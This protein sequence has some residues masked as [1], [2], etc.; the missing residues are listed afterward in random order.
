[1]S[2]EPSNPSEYDPS[3]SEPAEEV[4]DR[5]EVTPDGDESVLSSSEAAP[6]SQ[7]TQ[8]VIQNLWNQVQP[9]LRSTLIAALG[10][11]LSGI[12]WAIRRLEPSDSA[13]PGGQ[14]QQ[15][16]D[17]AMPDV[18]QGTEAPSAAAPPAPSPEPQGIWEQVRPRLISGSLLTLIAA[19]QG[20]GGLLKQLDAN[21]TVPPTI[22][23]A[24]AASPA[25]NRISPVFQQ[26]WQRWT[27]VLAF[28]RD[29]VPAMRQL[30]NTALTTIT[31]GVLAL[32]FWITSSLGSAPAAE[33]T[34][35]RSPELDKGEVPA[36][37]VSSKD[38]DTTEPAE[39]TPEQTLIA[40]LQ[41]Q[42][43]ELS[44][45]YADGLIQ[46][47]EANFL[48][49]RLTINVEPAWYDLAPQRQHQLA[50][51]MLERAQSLDFQSLE[52]L[53][54]EGD[55]IAR[56]PVVGSEMIFFK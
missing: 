52:I 20:A 56:S 27:G 16:V 21:A 25:W 7:T 6:I 1:M 31:V 28:V 11:A 36:A 55:R 23:A 10:A 54:A 2:S 47:V 29:R 45:Q 42:V 30:S 35:D 50:R 34:A 41:D 18:S 53:D 12:A 3:A 51:E 40:S 26:L 19:G 32:L 38:L 9:I 48:S 14:L 4:G 5:P 37:V 17:V 44:A 33:T 22:S 43:A 15:P 8:N 49:D 24:A 46:S 13:S 39:L